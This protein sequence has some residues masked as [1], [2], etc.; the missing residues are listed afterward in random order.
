MYIY[1]G[2]KNSLKCSCDASP[3]IN[4]FFSSVTYLSPTCFPLVNKWISLLEFN[5]ASGKI[6]LADL[7]S[8][9]TCVAVFP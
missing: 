1:K 8:V 2:S 6:R 7:C 4:P 3:G 9:A 5:H